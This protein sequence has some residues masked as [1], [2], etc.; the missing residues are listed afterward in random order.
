MD[1]LPSC[2]I[3]LERRTRHPT[4]HMAQDWERL[5]KVLPWYEDLREHREGLLSYLDII[6][7]SALFVHFNAIRDTHDRRAEE[8]VSRE[9]QCRVCGSTQ[10][11]K[12]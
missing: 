1:P 7:A 11:S 8:A 4:R 2:A 3:P 6:Y 12:R 5:H 9:D 10:G